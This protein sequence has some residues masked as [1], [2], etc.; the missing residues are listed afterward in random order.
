MII[1]VQQH[2]TAASTITLRPKSEEY[3]LRARLDSLAKP[4]DPNSFLCEF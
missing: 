1:T 3:E 2:A 4:M